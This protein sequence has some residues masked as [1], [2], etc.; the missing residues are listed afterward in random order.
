MAKTKTTKRRIQVKDLSTKEEVLSKKKQKKVK[1][2]EVGVLPVG[3]SGNFGSPTG[4]RP[5]APPPFGFDPLY[6]RQ[7]DSVF[8]AMDNYIRG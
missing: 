7:K 6:P 8:I 5:P 3:P 2:G 4:D 1:G